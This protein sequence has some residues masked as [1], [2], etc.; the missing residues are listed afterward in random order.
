MPTV[1][2]AAFMTPKAGQKPGIEIWRVEALKVVKKGLSDPAYKG[3]FFTG[4]SYLILHTRQVESA[5]RR[6]IHFWIGEESSQDEFAIAAYK[7]VELDCSLGG[8]PTQIRECQ[9][10]ESNEFLAL[11][12]N[13]KY[14]AGG[15][16]TGFKKVDRNAF[17]TR[18]LHIKGRRNIRV[19]EV[20]VS[21]ASLNSGDVFILDAGRAIFQWNGKT[22]SHVE[23]I[24]AM[25]VTKQIRDQER[26]G[27]A[28]I[29][30]IDEGKD[31]DAEF[32]AA[33]G[34]GKTAVKSDGGDDVLMER[35]SAEKISLHCVSNEGKAI[36]MTLVKRGTDH[37]DHS[38][39]KT[40]DAFILDTGSKQIHIWMGKKASPEEKLHA[41]TMADNYITASGGDVRKT[42]VVRHAEGAETPLFKQYFLNWKEPVSKGGKFSNVAAV[43]NST[44]FDVSSLSGAQR[45]PP[46]LPD[47]GKGATTVWVIRNFE[48]V[49][50]DAKSFGQFNSGDSY[51]ILYAYK[52]NGKDNWIIYFWLGA[53]STQDETSAA[54]IHAMQLDDSMG[55]SPVQV[56]VVQNKEPAHFYLIFKGKMIVHTGGYG[57]GFKNSDQ[58]DSFYDGTTTRMF[59]IKGSNEYNT[60]AIQVAAQSSALNSGDIYLVETATEVFTWCGKGA[61]G[62]ERQY[63]SAMKD[64][65]VPGERLDRNFVVI[66]AKTSTLIAEGKEPK[67]FW[68]VLGGKTAYL[69]EPEDA[70]VNQIPRLFQCSNDKGYFYAEEIYDFAQSDLIEEDVMMLDCGLELFVWIGKNANAE[71]KK[72]ALKLA[73]DY[74]KGDL[75][76]R[77]PDNTVLMVLQQSVEPPNFTG[78]F[79]GWADAPSAGPSYEE[80]KKAL[81][82][83]KAVPQAATSV[84]AELAKF[85]LGQTFTW[86]ELTGKSDA[87]EKVGMDLTKKEQFLI[88]AEFTSKFAMSLADFNK[89]PGWKREALKKKIGIF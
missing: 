70:P 25:E 50:V 77:T 73:I 80:L 43:K 31:D 9:G 55:G 22:A 3:E 61:T 17:N 13:L 18:L 62:D 36:E 82:S 28:T 76:G 44:A 57:S 69:E 79:M 15:V 74:I 33:L 87:L 35:A 39:L 37:I 66:P 84:A 85:D 78:H 56:R 72:G 83:G 14:V 19:S 68:D 10:E 67:A 75:S 16:A 34:C 40:E 45:R 58:K 38:D 6:N 81:A 89:L 12:K 21:A 54:A 4:D 26:G 46:I 71:E 60:R 5:L 41:F 24:K 47:D 59:Q 53:D 49:L 27:N 32:W 88:P 29:S 11:F 42:K 64:L 51:V 52:V 2:D 8:E 20:E 1:F 23:R 65:L 7:T 86:A 48:K 63:A 30:I